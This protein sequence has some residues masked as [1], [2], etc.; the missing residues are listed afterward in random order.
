MI[1]L[2]M[3]DLTAEKDQLEIA[4]PGSSMGTAAK[5]IN[6]LTITMITKEVKEEE[7]RR[8]RAE[9]IRPKADND[10]HHGPATNPDDPEADKV[11][12]LREVHN[13]HL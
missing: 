5:A 12:N 13:D 10:L 9:V 1:L 4:E 11:D 6:V 8:L 2:S 7:G 3:L